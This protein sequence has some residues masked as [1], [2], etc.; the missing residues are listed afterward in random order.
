MGEIAGAPLHSDF[1]EMDLTVFL[2]L[3]G[4]RE[5][6]VESQAGAAAAFLRLKFDYL[7]GVSP[8]APYTVHQTLLERA[9]E[10]C[11]MRNVP[12]AMHLAESRD[13][14]EFLQ[15]GVGPLRELLVERGQWED[16]AIS[17]TSKPLDYLQRLAAAP[18][19]LVIHG[20]YLDDE[21]I[22]FLA[23]HGDRMSLVYCPRTHAYFGH[24]PHPW[25]KLL[26]RSGSVALGTDSRASN[27]DLNMLEELRFLTHHGGA[28]PAEALEMGTLGGAAALG[29]DREYG[30]LTPGK[31]ATFVVVS[32]PDDADGEAY[33][34][35]L[36]PKSHPM[37]TFYRRMPVRPQRSP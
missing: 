13:E 10:L 35:L 23:Q 4:A 33:D 18:R 8:H 37:M 7:Q 25:R 2:E 32:V 16:G 12:L 27:P 14:I 29:I 9:V 30:T 28:S 34:Q 19:T 1:Q 24:D 6:D 21:E 26:E 22:N 11:R 31:T 20:N 17:G 5:I 36:H 15:T 3:R